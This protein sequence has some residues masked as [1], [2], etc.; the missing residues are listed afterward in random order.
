M[1]ATDLAD[2]AS[3]SRLP[4]PR[5]NDELV[6][7]ML[8]LPQEQATTLEAAA[9]DRGLTIGQMIRRLIRDFTAR[10]RLAGPFA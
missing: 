3:R 10:Q 4:G 6:E 7:M 5:D 2:G 8:L 9:Q 1:N